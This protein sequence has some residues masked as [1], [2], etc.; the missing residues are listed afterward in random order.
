MTPKPLEP[1]AVLPRAAG[2]F[3]ASGATSLILEV[4]WIRWLRLV[5]GSSSYAVAT[6]VA[7]FLLGLALGAWL[8][9][10]GRDRSAAAALRLYGKLQ[11]AIGPLAEFIQALLD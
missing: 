5:L 3:A 4:V 9:G 10:A 11:L 1:R 6:V 7:V 8:G 2:L